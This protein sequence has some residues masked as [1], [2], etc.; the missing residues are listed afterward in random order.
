METKPRI[1]KKRIKEKRKPFFNRDFKR[2]GIT[3]LELTVFIVFTIVFLLG[4]LHSDIY[5]YFFP[6]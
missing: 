4:I 6:S 1:I 5:N 2:M 3:Y